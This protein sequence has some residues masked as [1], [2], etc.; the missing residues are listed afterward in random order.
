[1]PGVIP[2]SVVLANLHHVDLAVENLSDLR[3][4]A[5]R[6][7]NALSYNDAQITELIL[8]A[9]AAYRKQMKD[10]VDA[11]TPTTARVNTRGNVVTITGSLLV[12]DL[13][14]T[15]K[16]QFTEPPRVAGNTL[17][18]GGEVD[19]QYLDYNAQASTVTVTSDTFACNLLNVTS[20]SNLSNL[21]AE[22]ANVTHLTTGDHRVLG[23][24]HMLGVD[25][26]QSVTDSSQVKSEVTF[27]STVTC[28]GAD[29][30]CSALVVGPLVVSDQYGSKSGSINMTNYG[31]MSC[32]GGMTVGG[33][34]LRPGYGYADGSV[35]L[36]NATYIRMPAGAELNPF[37]VFFT[38]GITVGSAGQINTSIS[39]F[40]SADFTAGPVTMQGGVT[41][42]NNGLHQPK[43]LYGVNQNTG[44]QAG[45]T[46][47]L[48]MFEKANTPVLSFDNTNG[49]HFQVNADGMYTMAFDHWRTN[50]YDSFA[51]ATW[52]IVHTNFQYGSDFTVTSPLQYGTNGLTRFFHAGDVFYI[53][54]VNQT[55]DYCEIYDGEGGTNLL[56]T[57]T[58]L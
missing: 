49:N 30:A 4:K 46:K 15:G 33:L 21:Y 11:A 2:V 26:V 54:F 51:N 27:N 10:E 57:Y 12:Q 58:L 56:I 35:D 1:M 47:L 31:D 7:G 25:I 19:L 9:D 48:N 40:A 17:S 14:V 8:A 55:G 20:T 50:S 37:G 3:T 52:N 34:T 6:T 23:N 5:K 24:V 44:V 22:T 16:T 36:T 28:T 53:Q 41:F 32:V 29:N 18:S 38:N 39:G 42:D 13:Q 43:G 45:T